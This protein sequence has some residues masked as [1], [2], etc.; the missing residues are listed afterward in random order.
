MPKSPSAYEPENKV[1][2]MQIR[3]IFCLFVFL[4]ATAVAQAE[5][6]KLNLDCADP[7]NS[8]RMAVKKTVGPLF[9][10]GADQAQLETA[11]TA[12]DKLVTGAAYCQI[13]LQSSTKKVSGIV[14]AE[15]R[16]LNQWFNRLADT[17]SLSVA[18]PSEPK[19]RDEYILFA[20]V[21]EFEP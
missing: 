8:G 3:L 6:E 7:V 18:K 5:D 17:F 12:L 20:E 4:F 14:I 13:E 19:W 1:V 10:N 16:S 2:T 21:Y 15:W 11:A 9:A